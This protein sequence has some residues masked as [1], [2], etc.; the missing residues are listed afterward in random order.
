MRVLCVHFSAGM[1]GQFLPEFLRHAC[2]S[3]CRD[4]TMPEA[5]MPVQEIARSLNV[6]DRTVVAMADKHADEITNLE[7]NFA[8]KL[9]R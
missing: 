7:R 9:R 8:K 2:I 3:H 5:G 6:S 1:A 4:E